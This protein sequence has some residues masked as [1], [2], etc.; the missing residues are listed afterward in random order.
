[1]P[2]SILPR[3]HLLCMWRFSV[4]N[5]GKL[6]VYYVHIGQQLNRIAQV[7]ELSFCVFL[8]GIAAWVETDDPLRLSRK[9]H[10]ILTSAAVCVSFD[11][12]LA[13][14]LTQPVHKGTTLRHAG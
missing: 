2:Y 9:R 1:M 5:T 12:Y 4:T 13:V 3:S 8:E 14:E 10:R 7:Q 6:K 11:L